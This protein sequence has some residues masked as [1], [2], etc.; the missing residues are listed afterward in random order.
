MTAEAAG[1]QTL[2]G[3]PSAPSSEQPFVSNGTQMLGR[4]ME[5]GVV[6]AGVG[7]NG[8]LGVVCVVGG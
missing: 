4:G 1:I 6:G 3:T 2:G 7:V 8:V 5:V